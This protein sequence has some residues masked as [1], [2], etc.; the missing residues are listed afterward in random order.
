[1]VLLSRPTAHPWLS[2]EGL[3]AGVVEDLYVVPTAGGVPKRLTFDNTWIFGPPT[4]TPDGRDIVFSSMRGGLASLWRVST[5]GGT[6]RRVPG[7]GVIA[8]FPSISP[9]GNQLV[10]QQMHF[11]EQLL[12]A[13]SE[14]RKTHRRDRP[15][16]LYRRRLRIQGG[17]SFLPMAKGLRSNRIAWAIRRFGPAIV[18][19]PIVGN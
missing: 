5:S 1:M 13:E 16:W 7:V 9:R 8:A 12:A 4:W 19:D 18:T 14:G 2:F 15:H 10:Y 6:P 17:R 3:C 11:T